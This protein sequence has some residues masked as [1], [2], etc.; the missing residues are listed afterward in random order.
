[1]WIQRIAVRHW[2][3]LESLEL[4][5]LEP[6]MNL[7]TGS[8]ESGKSRMVQALRFA[9]FES[10]KGKAKHKL[11]VQTLGVAPENPRVEVEF[12]HGGQ[13]WRIEKVFLATGT[14]TRLHGPGSTLD[15]DDAEARL[16]QLLGVGEAGNK[17]LKDEDAG[18]WPLLWVEQGDSRTSPTAGVNADARAQLQS[19]LGAE[20]GEVAAGAHG[21]QLLA[22]AREL[23]ERY[24]TA[25]SNNE[26]APIIDA[27]KRVEQAIE[28]LENARA[29]RDAVARM[30]D[31]LGICRDRD[32]EFGER[33]RETARE[34]QSVQSRVTEAQD[35]KQR[36]ALTAQQLENAKAAAQQAVASAQQQRTLADA[37][38]EREAG[39][40][41]LQKRCSEDGP[42]RERA[43]TDLDAAND[44]VEKAE[45]A[46]AAA[47]T[48]DTELKQRAKAEEAGNAHAVLG[49]RVAEAQRIER[50]MRRL[51]DDLL[52]LPKI[53]AA[54]LKALQVL[55]SDL[56]T[57][58]ATLQGASATVRIHA[59][60]DLS[61]ESAALAAGETRE[62]SIVENSELVLD[63]IARIE[64]HP[65]GGELAT[66]RDAVK[67]A[68][69]TLSA[70]LAELGVPDVDAA[71]QAARRRQQLDDELKAL[72][73]ELGHQAPEGREALERELRELAGQFDGGAGGVQRAATVDVGDHEGALNGSGG[74]ALDPVTPVALAAAESAAEAAR[75]AVEAARSRRDA[76]AGQVQALALELGKL[77][78]ELDSGRKE[79]ASQQRQ[80]DALPPAEALATQVHEAEQQLQNQRAL[81]A[82]AQ[83][84]YERLGGDGLQ[85]DLE[86]ARKAHDQLK[87]Q[88]KDNEKRIHELQALLQS[89]G[90]EGRHERVL[91]L[92][93]EHAQAE[94]AL[95]RILRDAGT[96]RRL[97]E[98][99]DSA[100]SQAQERLLGPVVARIRP[101]LADLFPGAELALDEELQL[102]GLR[103]AD[104]EMRFDFLSGGA[105]EQLALL[106]RIGLAEVLGTGESWPLVLDDAL[107]NTDAG[108]IRRVHRVLYDASRRMQILL[109]TCHAPLYDG[110][111]ADR[112]LALPARE[113][114]QRPV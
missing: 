40:D 80:L 71:E 70:R 60:R 114:S 55:Q 18:I 94:A 44:A 52:G 106:V 8:N 2:R 34:L 9:L 41:A 23:K 61:I 51:D 28:Q 82:Q 12:E 39:I 4:S 24:Y 98:V 38:R 100:S 67:D 66:L 74:R 22:R 59:D 6:G 58:R 96:A 46:R 105:R 93:A 50:A 88:A 85:S 62:F 112:T 54:A 97:F 108:R 11:D 103:G 111:G 101:R 48:A 30:A 53:D 63:G 7:I 79:L 69:A 35:A 43:R 47:I 14:P 77:E 26:R 110:L 3:G 32:T 1:M 49:A 109:F 87:S 75:D 99:L 20:V 42:K 37:I 83:T 104:G 78:T 95:E 33:T 92:E 84:D 73:V 36:V 15:G 10:T 31:E 16:A 65:G 107:V 27:R 5:G 113:R 17:G 64:I 19:V 102:R 25:K 76:I 68:E 89:A 91:D 45:R 21:Q 13:Q 81:A 72:R 86:R 90:D 29:A 57:A 56:G